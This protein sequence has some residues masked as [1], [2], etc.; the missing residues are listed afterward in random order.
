MKKTKIEPNIIITLDIHGYLNIPFIVRDNEGHIL[1]LCHVVKDYSF[2][3]TRK[4]VIEMLDNLI[5]EF[6]ADTIII[7]Q[8]QLFI[9][10]ID[11]Y[12]DPS[13]LRNIQLGFG[14][15]TSIDDKY[16]NTIKYILELPIQE[17]RRYVLNSSVKYSIDLYKAHILEQSL[18]E[19]ELTIIAEYNYYKALCLSESIWFDRLMDRKYQI[20]KGD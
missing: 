11:R 20:N 18:A 17:W 12:P 9:D 5:Q 7:E 15:K 3:K 19:E 2:Y 14:I 1:K 4:S 8:N 10:K 13:V 16:H 6:N